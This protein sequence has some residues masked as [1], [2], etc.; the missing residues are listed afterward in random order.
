MRISILSKQVNQLSGH[1]VVKIK[2]S[3]MK[4]P[5]R[6][7]FVSWNEFMP[8]NLSSSGINT[9]LRRISPFC[10]ILNPILFSIL[11]ALKPGAPFFT[12]NLQ[13]EKGITISRGYITFFS[14]NCNFNLMHNLKSNL[15]QSYQTPTYPFIWFVSVLRAKITSTS[16]KVL[17]PIQ[18]FCPSSIQPPD[19]WFTQET[20]T[21][22]SKSTGTELFVNKSWIGK[23]DAD[24]QDKNIVFRNQSMMPHVR[25]AL[26]RKR[27]PLKKRGTSPPLG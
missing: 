15:V 21:K 11:V 25:F 5:C 9:F 13:A 8:G 6:T 23:K 12:I 22:Q 1:M 14:W 19:T 17:F 27:S 26:S 4:W 24:W 16:A 2:R 20:W 18:R 10:T 7:F 3:T